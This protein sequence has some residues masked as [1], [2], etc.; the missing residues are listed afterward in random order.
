MLTKIIDLSLSYRPVV[1]LIT[2]ILVALGLYS[3]RALPFD[4]YPDTTPV[5]VTV[6]TVAPALSPLEIEQDITFPLE[7]AISGL[8]ALTEVRSV[9]KFGFSQ[10]TV[11]F[12]ED[13]DLLHAR[14]LVSERIQSANLPRSSFTPSLGPISTGLGEVFQYLITSDTRSPSELRTLHE[15]VVRPQMLTVPGTAE[16]N[17]WGGYE[18]QFHVVLDLQK[19]LQYDLSITD[20]Q[21]AL[22]QNNR[23][24]AG[25]IVHSGGESQLVQGLGLFEEIEDIES[26]VIASYDGV[27][28][29]VRDVARIQQDHQIRRGA[30]TANGEGEV[31]L[32]L[33]FMLMG[34]NSR[35]VTRALED[36]LQ[37][38]Q[39][40][41]PDD[42]S[43]TPVYTRSNLVNEVLHTVRE[44]LL[45]GALLIIAILF[46]LLGNFRAGFIVALAIPLS[47]L[48]AFNMM[49]AAGIAGTLLSLGALDFGLV[50][51]SSVIIVENAERKLAKI[52]D[53]RSIIEIVRDATIQVR[54]PTLFGE[55]IILIVYLPILT[56]E[57][58]EGK[59]FRPMALTVI[60]ALLGSMLISLTLMPVLASYVLKKAGRAHRDIWL[61]RHLKH[62][63]ANLVDWALGHR[64]IVLIA[65]LLIVANTA[66]LGLR[67]GTQFV[68][69]LKEDA[70]VINTVRM[71]GVSLDESIR[72][73]LQ[74]EEKLLHAF[75]DE[76]NNIWTRT[77]TGE[78][79]T[80]PMG[81]EVS[82]IFIDLHPRHLWTRASTHDELVA[83]MTA[84]L[85]AMPGMRSIFTQPIE[86]R[87]NEMLAGIRSD[88]GIK[89]YGDDFDLLT[90]KADEIRIL[91]EALPGARDVSAEQITGLPILQVDI[92][93]DA[94]ARH[95]TSTDEVLQYVE[96]LGNPVVGDV[97]EGLR[98]FDLVIRLDD[99]F[100]DY[101]EQLGDILVTT[102]YGRRIPLSELADFN[103][104]SAPSTIQRDWYQRRI[105][106]EA[107]IADE[108]LGGFVQKARN[109][110]DQNIDLPDGYHY[111]FGGQYQHLLRAQQRL[112]IVV[113]MALL[114]IFLLLFITYRRLSDVLRISTAIP[115]AAVGGILAL[116]LR[117]MPFS[118]A[119]GVGFVALFGIAVLGDMVLVSYL[120]QLIARNVPPVEAV[121]QAAITRMRP[122]LM[123][124]L[125]AAFGFL[126]MALNTGVGA[127]V[128]RPLATVVV[129]GIFTATLGTLVVMPVLCAI[130]EEAY[131]APR[132]NS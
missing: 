105:L 125:V 129:G 101:P 88:V 1:L 116:W 86:M 23:N 127:E 12:R 65:A 81:L 14:Q 73:G 109:A 17:T 130:L 53:D 93:R 117:D 60:F 106:I 9:S 49:L 48:F 28:L 11:V 89:L 18:K 44:N 37:Q 94:V 67:L 51:D 34:E 104:I 79:A 91:L 121:R 103:L 119:A 64:K 57:G 8:P 77:G 46:F 96:L 39:Q 70:V 61:I 108:D 75:P 24:V 131:A 26:T 124:S 20:V 47:L 19:L 110:I 42:V 5:Q 31:V 56:L 107:N 118:I 25:G 99:H 95:G 112:M 98:R 80:D 35:D 63:Y 15:W 58:V 43:L 33:G 32:G 82:D 71:A 84:E 22:R 54:K 76:I 90:Q 21:A 97:R 7:Q 87:V 55:L 68:P 114:L 30:V 120:R 4:A 100:R 6:N 16:I 27:P 41:L 36:K 83:A 13:F 85:D 78:V 62:L 72:Y 122:V 113:P 111:D 123:T 128:Q 92:D 3:F 74:L 115:F 126:P 40:S 29:F 50:V 59:L 45:V 66:L 69:R 102:S 10:I 38:T 2:A 132:S 52:T